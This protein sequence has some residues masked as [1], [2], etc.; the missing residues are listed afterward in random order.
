MSTEQS[1]MPR[2]FK[3]VAYPAWFFFIFILSLYLTFPISAVKAKVTDGAEV[4]LGRGKQ[5]RHGTDPVVQIGHLELWRLSGLAFK[6]MQV[7]LASTTPDPGAQLDIDELRLRV[8]LFSLLS[9]APAVHFE[10]DL[11][12]GEVEGDLVF[13]DEKAAQQTF[14]V[15]KAMASGKLD[16]AAAIESLALHIDG[17]SLD[18][19]PAIMAA[20]GLP[21]TGEVNLDVDLSLGPEAAKKGSGEIVVDVKGLS[22]G[23]GSKKIPMFGELTVPLVDAGTLSG[24]IVFENGKGKT[25]KLVLNGRDVKAELNGDIT[26]AKKLTMSRLNLP[27]WLKIEEKFF[28]EN[29]KFKAF[30]DFPGPHKKAMDKD[31]RMHFT[32][33]GTLKNRSF[34]LSR[35]GGKD[36]GRG[37]KKSR[38]RRRGG[39]TSRR[40]RK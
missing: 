34:A 19:A 5:G 8:G 32:L 9:G 25:Q 37:A 40:N 14:G 11:Y 10:A 23:P 31:K 38:S 15:L 39:K 28:N 2:W 20:V 33:R 17:V 29:P 36:K 21:L 24:K 7:Q 3:A 22:V 30:Y 27:G 13:A 35:N 12:G 26:L 4:A 16:P 1:T 6:H 18:R